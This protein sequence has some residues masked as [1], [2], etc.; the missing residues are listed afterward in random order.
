MDVSIA[1]TL[2]DWLLF[3]HI[4]AAMVWLGGVVALTA[5]ASLILRAREPDGV[6]RFVG[7]LRVIGPLVLAPAVVVLL[8]LGVGLVLDSDAWEFGQ[9]WIVVAL[10]LFAAAFAIG[11]AFQSRAAI[12]AQR[13]AAAG[14]HREALRQLGRWSW[15]M[16]AI[17]VLLVATTW[18]MVM[19]P[20][21]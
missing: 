8:G 12:G 11:A 5:L 14:D 15:G 4:L 3:L 18:D 19:K 2:Y 17:L 6:A 21:L 13:P 16:R 1:T 7:S 9:T 10:V 20:G